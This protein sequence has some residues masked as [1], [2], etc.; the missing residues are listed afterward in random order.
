MRV[1]ILLS[2][3]F[4]ALNVSA[5]DKTRNPV[6]WAD[7]PDISM[8]RVGDTYYMSSTTM[9]MNPGVPIMKSKNLIDWE[10]ASYAYET[11]G[12][13]DAF[14]LNNG[15]N[16]YGRGS[17]ASSLRYHNGTFYVS[18]FSNSSGM[19][20]IFSTKDPNKTPW[21]MKSF[22]PMVHDHSLFFDDD[23][24]VYM[25]S[26]GGKIGIRELKS[27]LSGIKEG[28]ERILVENADAITGKERGLP[29]EGAQA[30]K[31]NGKY[32]VFMITW[33]RGGMRTVLLYR[34]DHIMG[35]YEGRVVL[36]DKGVAQGGFIDTPDG[37]WYGYFFRD[38]GAVGRIPYLVPMEWED[39][40][41]VFGD[42]GIVPMTLNIEGEQPLIPQIFASD[43]FSRK[44]NEPDLPLV[45]QWNHN[46]NNDYWS[47]KER[48]GYLRLKTFRVDESFLNAKNTLTQRTFGP[49]CTGE[50][51]MDVSN[52]KDGDFAGLGLLQRKYGLVG[53]KMQDGKKYIFAGNAQDADRDH[54]NYREIETIPLQAKKAYFKVEG[55]FEDR[56]DIGFFYYSLDGKTWKPI[57]DTLKLRYDL[58]HFMGCRFALFNFATKETGGYVDFDYFKVGHE[59]SH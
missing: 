43:N 56:A 21:E 59:L 5:Q 14:E 12:N 17:W 52:M 33:P 57:G 41:P 13:I 1:F 34:S 55:N 22:R 49:A 32:Y 51:A 20:Y 3:M 25:F 46:P 36:E 53:V 18:T 9:H 35:P 30:F 28:T 16:T 45:W 42:D 44:N 7:V 48:K 8:I 50:I 47:V 4:F 31:V 10:M 27:D 58:L 37:K 40:W 2:F 38:F 29:A 24:K 39:G 15:Q 6:I 11:L 19:N 26:C 23:G 54:E